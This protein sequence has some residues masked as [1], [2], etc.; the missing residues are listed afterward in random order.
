MRTCDQPALGWTVVL[1]RQPAHI[2]Q[3]W[4]EGGYADVFELIYRYCGDRPAWT[5]ATSHPS[6]CGSVGTPDRGRRW[7]WARGP[8]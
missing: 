1:R 6:L 5:T 8:R 3:G 4:A 2:V 7:T